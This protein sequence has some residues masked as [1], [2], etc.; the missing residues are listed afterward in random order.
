MT[1]PFQEYLDIFRSEYLQDFIGLGGAA[2]KFLVPLEDYQY[3]RCRQELQRVAEEEGYSFAMVDAAT[4]KIHMIDRLFHEVARQVA[5]DDYAYKFLVGLIR[6]NEYQVPSERSEFN[7]QALATLNEIEERLLRREINKWLTEKIFK[8]F[9]MSQEFRIAMMQ[10][11][12]AELESQAVRRNICS[13]IQEWLTGE[14]RAISILKEAQ[15]FQKVGRH[16]ARHMFLSLTH[17]LKLVGVNG[18]VLCLDISRYMVARRPRTP[19]D[20]F[21]Y[22]IGAVLDAYE[23]L[24]QF[25]DATDNLEYCVILVIAPPEFLEDERRG[26]ARY[27]ALKMRIWDEVRDRQRDNPCAPLVSVSLCL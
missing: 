18:L 2:V 26:V 8:D 20:S 6:E 17:W 7:M 23:V 15:I 27:Q 5:W 22:G 25:I 11:C 21:Y 14:L 12:L 13:S 19:D 4:T 10:L 1:I 9:K 3:D 16:N 24:R